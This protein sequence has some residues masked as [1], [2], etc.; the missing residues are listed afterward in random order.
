MLVLQGLY[1]L[2]RN[3]R[4]HERSRRQRRNRRTASH[5]V[6][7]LASLKVLGGVTEESFTVQGFLAMVTVAITSCET[8]QYG[9]I[10][11]VPQILDLIFA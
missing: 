3:P 10:G 7:Q 1:A 8:P 9:L 2:V 5:S 11:L 4:S 6:H